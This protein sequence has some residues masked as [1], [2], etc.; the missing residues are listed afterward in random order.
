M[1]Q[2]IHRLRGYGIAATD[3]TIGKV[4]D[5]LFDDQSSVV[6]WWVID[7]GNWLPG[8]KVLLAPA[9]FSQPD[10]DAKLL[11]TSLSKLQVEESPDL[12]S[13]RPVDRQMEEAISRHY[14]WDPY[15]IG[16][17]PAF[18]APWGTAA[19]GALTPDR[20]EA[21]AIAAEFET[22]AAETVDPH[23]RSAEGILGYHVH[24]ADG[25]FGHVEDL[26]IADGLNRITHVVVDTGN[27]LPGRKVVVPIK[28][29]TDVDWFDQTISTGLT[30][31]QI[32]QS[33]E[34]HADRPLEAE[35]ATSEDA[36]GYWKL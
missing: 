16:D 19:V 2:T 1:P 32:E 22:S 33:P 6:R 34:F 8:R 30:R 23:L 26:V 10:A 11:P 21:D 13:D 35:G 24:A 28:R 3:G 7:T 20:D 14:A 4:S 29:F 25:E 9:A 15:S 31:E 27:W 18:I 36:I 12:A 17:V 5:A